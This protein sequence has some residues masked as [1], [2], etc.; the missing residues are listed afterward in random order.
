M[1]I[2]AT[3][4]GLSVRYGRTLAVD[5]LSFDVRA[6]EVLAVI[7]PN[8]SGKTS[9]IEVLEGLRLPSAGISLSIAPRPLKNSEGEFP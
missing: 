5:N 9:A 1:D 4:S 7:G 2:L 3:I 6:Q 8:G